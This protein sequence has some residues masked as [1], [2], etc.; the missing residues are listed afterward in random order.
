MKTIFTAQQADRRI[1]LITLLPNYTFTPPKQ[2]RRQVH[3]IYATQHRVI[4]FNSVQAYEGSTSMPLA[5]V[6]RIHI[7]SGEVESMREQ[8][9]VLLTH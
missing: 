6:Q 7:T 3:K 1:T 2:G 9:Q 8:A 5:Q 4:A